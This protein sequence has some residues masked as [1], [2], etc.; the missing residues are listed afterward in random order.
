MPPLTVASPCDWA[1]RN[2]SQREGLPQFVVEHLGVNNP[3]RRSKATCQRRRR[4]STSVLTRDALQCSQSL[5]WTCHDPRELGAL[6]SPISAKEVL[7]IA[8]ST[9]LHAPILTQR[10]PRWARLRFDRVRGVELRDRFRGALVG[11]AVEEPSSRPGRMAVGRGR[12]DITAMYPFLTSDGRFYQH[13]M[14]SGS[15][16][17]GRHVI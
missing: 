4:S 2:T 14:N 11:G 17:C 6:R 3:G 8:C 1:T 16:F 12:L 13:G 5:C 15:S 7:G 9:E 10:D